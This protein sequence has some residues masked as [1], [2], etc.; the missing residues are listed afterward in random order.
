MKGTI[1]TD[2]RYTLGE[3]KHATMEDTIDGIDERLMLKPEFTSQV[4]FL[5]LVGFEI[6]YRKYILL[7]SK[8]PHTMVDIDK[9]VEALEALRDA[10]IKKLKL[11]M[12]GK[13]VEDNSL[14]DLPLKVE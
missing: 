11:V 7:M 2:R 6:A 4:R 13:S 9:A 8:Y 12:N 10:E 5:Q 14:E 1:R 3:Y